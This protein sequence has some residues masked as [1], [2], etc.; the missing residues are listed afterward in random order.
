VKFLRLGGLG[1]DQERERE[2]KGE[3]SMVYVVKS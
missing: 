3:V 2:E 1:R